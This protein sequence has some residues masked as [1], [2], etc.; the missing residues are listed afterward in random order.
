[1]KI[2][3]GLIDF[4]SNNGISVMLAE[5]GAFLQSTDPGLREGGKRAERTNAG[6][7]SNVSA[8]LL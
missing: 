5:M 6:S 7:L 3:S 8:D 1:M 2:P 4:P